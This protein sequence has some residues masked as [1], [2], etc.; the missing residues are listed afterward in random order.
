MHEHAI[1][2]GR[3]AD[4]RRHPDGINSELQISRV[5]TWRRRLPSMLLICVPLS[6][7]LFAF[8]VPLIQIQLR[9]SRNGAI[10]REVAEALQVQFPGP[11]YNGAASYE[12]ET[13]Y[14]TVWEEVDK[15]R[16]PDVERWLRAHKAERGIAPKIWLSY[17][18]DG[19]DVPPT[20]F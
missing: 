8:V 6:L 10:A 11:R 14:I 16:R 2:S 15:A 19:I 13:V 17:G 12:K 18:D 9:L 20:K 3:P 5:S 1:Q 4:L 7:V